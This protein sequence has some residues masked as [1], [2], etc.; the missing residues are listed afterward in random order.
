MDRFAATRSFVRARLARAVCVGT[1]SFSPIV[2]HSSGVSPYLPL[3]L[4]PEIESQIERVLILADKP[5]LVRPIPAATVLDALPAA[6]EVDPA[7]CSRVRRFLSRYTNTAGISDASLE[8]AASDGAISLP[9]A[10]GMTSDSTWRVSAHGFWQPSA[11]GLVT[12]GGVA[13]EDG[14]VPAGSMISLGFEY[15]QLDL[16]FRDHWFSPFTQSAMLISTQAQTLPSATLSNYTPIT[17]LG[18]RYEL[19]LAEMEHSDR[20]RIGDRYTS[21]NPRLAGIQL[22]IEPAAGWSVAANRLVQFGGGERGGKSVKDFF[23]ALWN[24]RDYDTRGFTSQEEEFGNQAAAWT[25][26]FIYP[27]PVPFSVYLEY[28][29]EDRSYEG[30]YRFGNAALS[31]GIKFP[32]LWHR[33]DL[34]YE[35]SDWQ[36]SWY[37]H[38]IYRDGLT[39]E[40]HVLGHWGGDARRLGHG[41]GAQSHTLMLGWRPPFGGTANLRLRT[42]A[43]RERPSDGL[44]PYDRA[45]DA[46]ISYARSIDG[47]TVGGELMGGSD[48]FGE[49]FWR[50]SGFVRVG[51]EWD[52]PAGIWASRPR[53]PGGEV[54]V[55]A[56]INVS[57][58][59]TIVDEYEPRLHTDEEVAGHIGLGARRSVS[60]RGDLGVRIE[61]D[62]V[63]DSTLLAVRALDYRYRLGEAFALTGFLGA[64][65]YHVGLPAYGYY[66]GVGLQWR[67]ALPRMDLN[68]DARYA[69][70]VAR[71]KLLPSDPPTITRNDIFYDIWSMAL[72]LSYRW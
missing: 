8:L 45:Y 20:I 55:D 58:V 35:A 38:S 71:D 21:G 24:P 51:D 41:I 47:W 39:H 49:T 15:A 27:G 18:I 52:G 30:N 11:Y 2:A 19:F 70:R 64:A 3:H 28:A 32:S 9:N 42:L 17:R 13:Y 72:Y 22:S 48:V 50:L 36:N 56:G 53:P 54:F 68:L 7:L 4:S 69:D 67:N 34:T 25:S 33:F 5:T 57:R 37:I 1:L 43:N 59:R 44:A 26:Q 12:L 63:N 46:T 16:G 6:C 40:G 23:N 14:S 29:G 60:K 61:L 10:R 65:R 62:S 31:V 66:G